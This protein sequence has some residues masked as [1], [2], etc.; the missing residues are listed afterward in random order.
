MKKNN[1]NL[2]KNINR[3]NSSIRIKKQ[4][5]Y[6]KQQQLEKLKCHEK[7]EFLHN[8]SKTVGME[9]ITTIDQAI[10][11]ESNKNMNRSSRTT[12]IINKKSTRILKCHE[13]SEFLKNYSKIVRM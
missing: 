12:R 10:V 8:Y 13:K 2:N 9:A 3:S 5:V 11:Y 1:K 4:N 7:S 6:N